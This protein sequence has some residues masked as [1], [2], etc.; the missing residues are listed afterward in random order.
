VVD[1][2]QD[3]VE[4]LI[5]ALQYQCVDR[6]VQEKVRGVAAFRLGELK[7]VQA[8]GALKQSLDD[9]DYGTRLSAAGALGNIGEPALPILIDALEADDPWAI[10]SA[11]GKIGPAAQSSV[12]SLLPLLRHADWRIRLEVIRTLEAIGSVGPEVKAL[13]KDPEDLVRNAARN[14]LG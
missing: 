2:I 7:A 12:P 8:L 11:L 4:A 3:S 10:I 9:P 1:P 5:D 14:A 13:L 6:A